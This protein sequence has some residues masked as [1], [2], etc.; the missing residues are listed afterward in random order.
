[1]LME[2]ENIYLRSL[3]VNDAELFYVWSCD[4][5]VTRYSL[6]SYAYPQSKTDMSSWLSGINSERS[7]VYFGIC[8]KEDDQ[9]IGYAGISSIST[10]NR[11]GE[12][13]ILIGNKA[14]WG[15]GIG[16]LVTKLVTHYAIKT[17]GLHRVQLTA[18][19]RNTAAMNA[20]RKAGYQHEGVMR[21]AGF[22]DG[23]FVDKVIM[24]VLSTEW[25]G[26]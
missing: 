9:L 22:R 1:M 5:D 4:R 12:F 13:F 26:F 8:C 25:T 3:D 19:T 24:S 20:Y 11:S 10:L 14:C 16:T 18:Y 7:N 6:S 15:Q 17:L 2:A 23:Q 21:Q